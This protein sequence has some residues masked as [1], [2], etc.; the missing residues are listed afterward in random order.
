MSRFVHFEL[1]AD[2]PER[3][4]HFYEKV[5]GWQAQKWDGPMDYWMLTTGPEDQP[6]IN[7]A[8]A[9]R[10]EQFTVPINTVDVESVDDVA[11]RIESAGGTIV[12][13]KRAVPGVGWLVYFADTEGNVSGAMQMDES[14]T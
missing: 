3:A 7:G 10:E 14:A 13:P 1:P 4:V 8:I 12:V 6:G 5:F 9:P 2:N 11:R